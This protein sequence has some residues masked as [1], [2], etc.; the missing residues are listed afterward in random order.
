M[1]KPF[2]EP[3]TDEQLAELAEGIK[4]EPH[5]T[6]DMDVH[7]WTI[8]CFLARHADAKEKE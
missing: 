8:E 6:I 7:Y 2:R 5:G 3:F 1:T 4:Q